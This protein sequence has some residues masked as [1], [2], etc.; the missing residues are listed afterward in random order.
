MPNELLHHIAGFVGTAPRVSESLNNLRNLALVN[1]HF[2]AVINQH[3]TS[4]IQPHLN[5]ITA[6]RRELHIRM[7]NAS[8]AMGENGDYGSDFEE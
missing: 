3:H 5:R 6:Q 2:N 1:R 8:D 4:L 7:W